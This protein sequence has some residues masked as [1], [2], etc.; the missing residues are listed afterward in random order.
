MRVTVETQ[1]AASVVRATL[2]G[3]ALDIGL[4]VASLEVRSDL[5]A[6]PSL[7]GNGGRGRGGRG[8]VSA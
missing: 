7:S 3:R 4:V 1:E 5:A 8:P 6:L 2:H